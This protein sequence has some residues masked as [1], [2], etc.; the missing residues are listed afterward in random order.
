MKRNFLLLFLF[1]FF[2]AVSSGQAYRTSAGLRAGIPYG[3]TLRHFINKTNV[4]ESIVAG[5]PG[6]F[7]G[8]I[9]LPVQQGGTE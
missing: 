5:T 2:S 8:A 4:L 3:L 1:L 7:F 6:G 9:F